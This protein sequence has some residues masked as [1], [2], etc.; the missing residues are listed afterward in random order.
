MATKSPSSNSSTREDSDGVT[1]EAIHSDRAHRERDRDSISTVTS[2][3][4][5]AQSEKYNEKGVVRTTSG[6]DVQRAEAEFAELSKEFSRSSNIERKL[7]RTQSRRSHK[8]Q[9][10]TDVEK[11]HDESEVSSEEPFDLETVLRGNRDEEESAGIKSK[12]IGVVWDGLTVSGIGGVKNYVKVS[13]LQF[14]C[15]MPLDGGQ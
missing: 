8:G 10:I 3:D 14:W 15:S 11:G 6:V 1:Y 4:H 13:T 2:N 12:H 7:S 5:H 9:T